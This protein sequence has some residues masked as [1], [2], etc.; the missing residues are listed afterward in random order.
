MLPVDERVLPFIGR[1][2]RLTDKYISD[3]NFCVVKGALYR[4]IKTEDGEVGFICSDADD[5]QLHY[6]RY[7]Y[8][9][10]SSLV[11]HETEEVF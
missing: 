10:A 7:E 1:Y 3:Y 2:I 9:D 6:L 4:V 11:E 5:P 8:I